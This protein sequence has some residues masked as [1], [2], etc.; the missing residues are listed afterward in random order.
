MPPYAFPERRQRCNCQCVYSCPAQA[1]ARIAMFSHAHA[2]GV[3]TLL[4]QSLQSSEAAAG[5][6]GGRCGLSPHLSC[7]L[8]SARWF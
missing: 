1:P 8:A 3:P 4:T 5:G 6:R 2:S 7:M